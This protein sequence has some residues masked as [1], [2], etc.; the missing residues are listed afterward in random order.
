MHA[1]RS[2]RAVERLGPARIPIAVSYAFEAPDRMRAVTD[3]GFQRVAI[4]PFDYTRDRSDQPW[5]SSTAEPIDATRLTWDGT[6]VQAARLLG[7]S[8]IAGVHATV[9]SFFQG[10]SQE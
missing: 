1:L 4:G 10:D 7:R 2:Y 9:V 8:D 3:S 5:R 6:S